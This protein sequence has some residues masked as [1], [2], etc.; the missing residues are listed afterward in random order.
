MMSSAKQGQRKGSGMAEQ[1]RATIREQ[2][3]YASGMLWGTELG[4]LGTTGQL[5]QVH[6]EHIRLLTGIVETLRTLAAEEDE[7]ARTHNADASR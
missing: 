3:E 6:H 5:Q 2:L 7:H 1:E 4:L